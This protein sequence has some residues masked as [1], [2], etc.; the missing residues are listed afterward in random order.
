MLA[1][2]ASADARLEEEL[3]H[4]VRQII[5]RAVASEGVIDIFAAAGLEKPDIAILS[6]EFLAKVRGM[7][8]RNL[9]VELLQKL[10]KGELTDRWRKNVVQARSFAE[11]LEE[12]LRRYQNRAIEAAQVI[13]E[14]IQLARD[15]REANGPRREAWAHGRRTRLLRRCLPVPAEP[16]GRGESL[17]ERGSSPVRTTRSISWRIALTSS[18]TATHRPDVARLFFPTVPP[19]ALS[20]E[21]C[22]LTKNARSHQ[23][24]KTKSPNARKGALDSPSSNSRRTGRIDA[25]TNKR[26]QRS[27]ENQR[28][29]P[30][31][32]DKGQVSSRPAKTS[33]Q[34]SE[35]TDT[36][37]RDAQSRA[38]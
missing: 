29:W 19:W 37:S 24:L 7:P 5:S 2:R 20:F 9:A 12:T 31:L 23:S 32:N 17:P 16:P 8:Q 22:E 4:A 11:M 14:L 15:L 21:D 18:E 27:S 30:N 13:E 28:R 35:D 25:N 3:D 1:K 36:T 26:S 38:A 10:L 34:H 33:K 6:D